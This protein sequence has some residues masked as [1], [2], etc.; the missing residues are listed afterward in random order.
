M[1]NFIKADVN[2]PIRDPKAALNAFAK[3]LSRKVAPDIRVNVVA[4]GNIY[5]PGGSW[6]DK[7]KKEEG[8]KERKLRKILR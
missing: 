5:F 8:R 7:M 6:D 4:P 2:N 1:V 3:N